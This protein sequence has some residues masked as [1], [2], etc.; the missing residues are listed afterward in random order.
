MA[1][2]DLSRFHAEEL[3]GMLREALFAPL[4]QEQ[5]DCFLISGGGN[6]MVGNRRLARLVAA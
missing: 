1:P 3:M 4:A 6:D 5:P 2:I